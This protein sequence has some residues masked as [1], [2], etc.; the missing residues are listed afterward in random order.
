MGVMEIILGVSSIT[1]VKSFIKFL[2][3]VE[4]EIAKKW[5]IGL[6]HYDDVVERLALHKNLVE[7][8]EKYPKHYG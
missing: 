7:L 1:G 3:F 6:L 8:A 2:Q 5:K 4:I